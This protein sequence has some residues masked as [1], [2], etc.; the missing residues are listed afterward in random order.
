MR[1]SFSR[2]RMATVAVSLVVL[3]VT[4]CQTTT[5]SKSSSSS[6]NWF[7][8][9]KKKPA[10]STL[11]STA[12]PS[13]NLPAPPSNTATP[14]PVPSYAQTPTSP[15]YGP[16][17]TS[18]S[19]PAPGANLTNN[20]A[21]GAGS[22]YSANTP[23]NN[24]VGRPGADNAGASP[25][26]RT[27]GNT[28][29]GAYTPAGHAENFAQ[30]PAGG[31][32]GNI[33]PSRTA[34]GYQGS[35]PNTAGTAASTNPAY[36]PNGSGYGQNANAG[37]AANDRGQ[38]WAGNGMDSGAARNA[39]APAYDSASR[40]AAGGYGQRSGQDP[41]AAAAYPPDVRGGSAAPSYGQAPTGY[42]N[43]NANPNS[44]NYS[45]PG[46]AFGQDR[47]PQPSSYA[48]TAGT[49]ADATSG[50]GAGGYRPGST[51]R[52]TRFGSS[53]QIN[54]NGA[55]SVQSASFNTGRDGDSR[56]SVSD[57]NSSGGVSSG[58]GD[59]DTGS[60]DPPGRT[61]AGGAASSPYSGTYRR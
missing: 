19:N 1:T 45:P 43:A 24:Q 16:V 61:A 52:P 55:D 34:G 17:G 29:P 35:Y 27:A 46:G 10:S 42:Q 30:P 54:V 8:W 40:P 14:N 20:G 39:A 21:A 56:A 18:M 3:C 36:A 44:N 25:Y 60:A 37:T 4:G 48:D 32:Y 11:G 5:P 15:G 47:G 22:G 51:G 53:Q 2:V 58:S 7:S 9:G 59:Y 57:R 23:Y 41:G 26:A 50:S 49:R 31:A 38:V 13:G 6:T 12:K 28:M 33:A